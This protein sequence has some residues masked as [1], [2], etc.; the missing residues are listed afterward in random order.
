MIYSFTDGYLRIYLWE[1]GKII[2]GMSKK[3]KVIGLMSGTS[4]DGVDLAYCEF[5][6]NGVWSYN[7]L[8]GKTYAYTQKWQDLL[9]NI[10]DIED[11]HIEVIHQ[12]LGEY[13]GRLIQNFCQE[14]QVV[15]DFV[16]SHGHTVFHQPEMGK[17]LQ[18]GS[19]S[20]IGRLTHLTV[21]N[22]FRSKDIKL[23]GQ[24]A[25]LVPIGDHLLFSEYDC[26]LNL[27][28]ISNI[29]FLEDGQRRA[30][31][32]CPMNMAL[33]ELARLTGKMYDDKGS[34]ASEGQLNEDLL[35]RLN[36]L[37]YYKKSAPKSLGAEW[38]KDK[39]RD[40]LFEKRLLTS[41]CLRTVVEHIA[42]Q[43]SLATKQYTK[44]KMLVTGGG[45][46]NDFF[47]SR[48]KA[49]CAPEIILP[50]KKIIDYKEAMIFAFL[51][52]LRMETKNNVLSSVTGSSKDHCSG[53]I[54]NP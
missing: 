26:C 7:I 25:P 54:H 28:G 9:V 1:D 41:D 13:Y 43:I 50:E 44:G 39:F 18:I 14:F 27:G 36:D 22:D 48:L 19:G 29:S 3:Y 30:Y 40:V 21:V 23:G 15:P 24:G 5:E 51:G 11:R 34:L 45:A 46:F 2:S 49:L 33:N 37:E 8:F 16:S 53:V 32:I 38:Y 35:N 4:M 20:S 31:D 52:V 12:D 47:I 10:V 42:I 17:T 6:N